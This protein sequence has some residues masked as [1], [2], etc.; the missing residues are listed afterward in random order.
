MKNINNTSRDQYLAGSYKPLTTDSSTLVSSSKYLNSA[1][2]RDVLAQE[3]LRKDGWD[4]PTTALLPE[5]A[6]AINEVNSYEDDLRAVTQE[7]ERLP[8]FAAFLDER[9]L[10]N[11]RSEDLRRC[12]PGTLGAEVFEYLTSTGM[13]IN[14]QREA[15]VFNDDLHYYTRRSGQCHDIEHVV[16]GFGPNPWGEIALIF[17]KAT[18]ESNY[19]SP[20]V[21]SILHR[22]ILTVTGAYLIKTNLHYPQLVPGLLDAFSLGVEMAKRVPKQFLYIKWEN[23]WDTPLDEVRRELNIYGYPPK[24]AWDWTDQE[25]RG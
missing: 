25:H 14:F 17:F 2:L 8:E 5:F 21:A 20:T 24:G 16:T 13:D 1:R 11:L 12:A 19:F 23:H 7:R 9:F 22:Q 6:Q 4:I 3:A 15:E 18:M 10:S